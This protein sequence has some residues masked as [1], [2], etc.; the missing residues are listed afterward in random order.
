[1]ANSI[2]ETKILLEGFR[3]FAIKE[4]EKPAEG[5]EIVR[6]FDFDG[7]LFEPQDELFKNPLWRSL[8]KSAD[9]KKIMAIGKQSA[10]EEVLTKLK[11][12]N[13]GGKPV[14]SYVVSLVGST[15]FPITG[16][17]LADLALKNDVGL[18][19]FVDKIDKTAEF[20]KAK[21]Q[22]VSQKSEDP[23]R[24]F[25]KKYTRLKDIILDKS[26]TEIE[27]LK[28]KISFYE[29]YPVDGTKQEQAAVK[30]KYGVKQYQP[31]FDLKNAK[32]VVQEF[33]ESTSNKE[34]VDSLDNERLVAIQKQLIEEFLKAK[35]ASVVRVDV[36]SSLAE[37][38]SE[39]Q[40][41]ELVKGTSGKRPLVQKIASE[42]KGASFEIYDNLP[43]SLNDM[44][45]GVTN[46]IAPSEEEKSSL[47][48]QGKLKKF[49][50]GEDGS[51][52]DQSFGRVSTSKSETPEQASQ[53]DVT[54]A[55]RKFDQIKRRLFD[56]FKILLT[57]G[58]KGRPSSEKRKAFA[59]GLN[60]W[61]SDKK[62]AE[63]YGDLIKVLNA[64][65][66]SKTENPST[67]TSDAIKLRDEVFNTSE[68]II[69]LFDLLNTFTTSGDEE[70]LKNDILSKMPK[71]VPSSD[72]EDYEGDRD[73][74]ESIY[75]ELER[76]QTNRK[77]TF[78]I[79]SKK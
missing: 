53:R 71:T 29:E 38:T 33:E 63:Q 27:A 55:Q 26:V 28:K 49:L 13:F 12:T 67:T 46:V 16:H 21:E 64:M 15:G 23:L 40:G 31:S 78:S 10:N 73:L 69:R 66:F 35:S 50:V 42:N 48:V 4:A 8:L 75:E 7:T 57:G 76:L 60:A 41:Y 72:E 19:S 9:Y 65:L 47:I 5:V 79:T 18:T 39:E 32:A 45:V 77:Y 20:K 17:K 74:D 44:V 62:N 24:S 6:V 37:R 2:R 43:Q 25:F 22:A 14:K 56:D 51:I 36:K 3:R 11:E 70:K 58:A 54:G 34:S 68:K 61:M 59:D 30:Q 1:M 52:Q